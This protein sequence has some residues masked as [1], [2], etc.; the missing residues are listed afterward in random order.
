MAKCLASDFV[1]LV[2]SATVLSATVLVLD[3]CFS[4]DDA[5]RG[6]KR[7]AG[8]CGPIGRIAILGLFVYEHEH[9][10]EHEKK[11]EQYGAQKSPTVIFF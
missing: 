9:E 3:G 6:S 5:D 1:V 7:F 8:T 11:L 4:C 2:L 10:H